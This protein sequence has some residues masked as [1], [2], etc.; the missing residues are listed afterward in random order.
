[1]QGRK[2]ACVVGALCLLAMGRDTAAA[3]DA[4]LFRVFMKDGS[5]L[6]SYG[7]FAVVADRVVF[8]MPTA[9]TPNPP[10]HLVDIPAGNVDWA[11]TNRY[12]ESARADHYLATQAESDYLKLSTDIV[13][14]LDRVSMTYDAARRLEIVESAR[15]R[16]AGWPAAH[17]NYRSSDVLQ[18]L[19]MLDEA[20]A[21]LRAATGGEQ[22]ALNFSAF[23]QLP[24]VLEPLMPA[25]TPQQALEQVLLVARL[26]GSPEERKSLLASALAA[27]DRDAAA[28][29]ETWA[30]EMRAATRAQFDA[31]VRVDRSYTALTQTM[32]GLAQTHA[33]AANV[34]GVQTVL[35]RIRERDA[36]LGGRRPDTV[37]ALVRS[38]EVSLDAAR[39]LR[40]ERDRWSMRAPA[41]RRYRQEMATP[42]ELF[43][44]LKPSL[45]DIRALSGSTGATLAAIERLVAELVNAAG[46]IEPPSELA[47]A[48]ALLVSAAQLADNAARIRREATLDGNIARAWDASS[49]AAGA[50]LLGA[51]ARSEMQAVFRIPQLR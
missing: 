16:L 1:M 13:Q 45:E 2:L 21:D 47:A 22:F 50:L 24:P 4:T 25:P 18:M 17:Y 48:H 9:A 36:R 19:Q 30:R 43:S 14:T 46:M 38:V 10:L 20:I 5:A 33:K 51:R 31:E 15:A 44:R 28:L 35:D 42:F 27:F 26:S 23:V 3:E 40:L 6:V 41:F 49:A 32:M 7:E 8:S 29:P 11:R 12:T 37:L 39:Q 34:K